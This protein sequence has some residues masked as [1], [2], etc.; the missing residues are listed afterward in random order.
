MSRLLDRKP[1]I[2]GLYNM[3]FFRLT[4]VLVYVFIVNMPDLYE[5]YIVINKTNTNQ[6]NLKHLYRYMHTTNC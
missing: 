2:V 6:S 5:L 1:S 3:Q 4:S